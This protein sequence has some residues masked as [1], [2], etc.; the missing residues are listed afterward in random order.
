MAQQ[1]SLEYILIRSRLVH[2]GAIGLCFNQS[3]SLIV[4]IDVGFGGLDPLSLMLQIPALML[5]LN[6]KRPSSAI[7]PLQ[8]TALR[9]PLCTQK[10]TL[11]DRC[12]FLFLDGAWMNSY[13]SPREEG[14]FFG[15]RTF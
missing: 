6:R 13:L 7:Q 9:F 3:H 1:A 12:G 11:D 5:V 2:Y 14:M 8:G 15:R 4:Q 10:A